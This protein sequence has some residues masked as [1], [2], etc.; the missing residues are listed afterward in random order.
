MA[1]V[2][3]G[4]VG[5]IVGTSIVGAGVS[6]YAAGEQADAAEAAGNMSLSATRE[7]NALT[8]QMHEE[9]RED[10]EP[11]RMAGENA[12][13]RLEERPDF[14]FTAE[15][16]EFMADPGYEFRLQE[17]INALDRSAASK[18]R[19]LSGAQDKAV[20]KYAGDMASKE[21]GNA[22]GRWQSEEG[23]RFSREQTEYNTN[24]NRDRYLAGQGQAAAAG[25]AA[26]GNDM[27]RTTANTTMSGAAQAGNAVIAGGNAMAQG[28]EN[29]GTAINTGVENYLLTI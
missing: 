27:A 19:L 25:S 6:M 5:A 22:F 21:Y 2:I 20:T 8:R 10:L 12:I 4:T 11:W 29:F 15:E 24:D 3:G 14:S 23:N 1:I 26:A 28:A 9:G 18:G 17:G 13:K 7:S 16:F